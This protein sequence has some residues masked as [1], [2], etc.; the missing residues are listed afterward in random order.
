MQG[1]HEYFH[2][3]IL[4]KEFKLEFHPINML[5]R[6]LEGRECAYPVK[7]QGDL[8]FKFRRP[9]T[10]IYDYLVTEGKPFV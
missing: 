4:F 9:I 3:Y 2:K 8:I 6:L 1:F 7:C 10:F 5:E